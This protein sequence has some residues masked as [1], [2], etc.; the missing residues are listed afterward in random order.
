MNPA[1][2]L[3]LHHSATSA[4]RRRHK[5]KLLSKPPSSLVREG[6]QAVPVQPMY[7]DVPDDRKEE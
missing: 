3:L 5:R 7:R 4:S 2:S 1:L 6:N